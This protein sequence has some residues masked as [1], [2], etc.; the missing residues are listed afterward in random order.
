MTVLVVVGAALAV[1]V[2]IVGILAALGIAGF[3]SYLARAKGAEGKAEAYRLARGIVRCAESGGVNAA[4]GATLPP[5]A[6]PV[7]ASL[8]EV[9]GRKYLSSPGDWSN[10]SYECAA[11]EMSVPQYFQYE[12]QLTSPTSGKAVARADLD[13]DGK[14]DQEY[15]SVV[16]CSGTTCSAPMPVGP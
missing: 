1:V 5:S 4:S 13:G 11:F 2:V 3:R 12:W 8:S 16:T 9:S 7:P 10:P 14:I 15:A 6:P